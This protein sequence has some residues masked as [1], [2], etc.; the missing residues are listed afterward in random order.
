MRDIADRAG[1]SKATVSHV[2]NGTRFVGEE[3]RDNVLRAIAELEYRPSA[4]ARS[5]ATRRTQTIG[6]IS[7]DVSFPFLGETLLGIGDVLRPKGYSIF[8]FHTPGLAEREIENLDLA[9]RDRVDGIIALATSQRWHAT[10]YADL[11]NIPIVFMDRPFDGLTGPYVGPNNAG[12]ATLAV[13][14]FLNCGMTEIGI[15]TG[16]QDLLNMGE[17]LAGFREAMATRGLP[18]PDEWIFSSPLDAEGGYAAMMALLALPRRPR[19]VLINSEQL[20]LGALRALP[21]AAVRCPEDLGLISFDEYPWAAVACPPL[22]TVRVPNR[23][24]GRTAAETLL[25]MLQ[26]GEPVAAPAPLPCELVLR[27]SCCAAHS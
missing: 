15:L 18:V 11:K 14:H 25:T 16:P 7:S 26:G 5:L 13:E 19:A 9:L 20:T 17:R 1:V 3:T 10:T 27:R 22:T 12:G 6:V 4:I 24:M 8:L 23:E 21:E 2:I